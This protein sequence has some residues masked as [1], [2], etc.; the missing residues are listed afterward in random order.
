MFCQM[1]KCV[2]EHNFFCNTQYW[3]IVGHR[4]AISSFDHLFQNPSIPQKIAHL[5]A[6][7]IKWTLKVIVQ[8]GE[9]VKN[10]LSMN[11]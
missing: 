8:N 2:L 6:K 11:A 10:K 7:L 5:L 3:S 9:N 1:H 4:W